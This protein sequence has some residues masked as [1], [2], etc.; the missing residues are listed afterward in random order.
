[1]HGP[2]S[3]WSSLRKPYVVMASALE[4]RRW[5]GS[6]TTTEDGNVPEASSKV[7]LRSLVESSIGD[8]CK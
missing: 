7:E 4:A 6:A 8:C 5:E 3:S 2:G 1:M